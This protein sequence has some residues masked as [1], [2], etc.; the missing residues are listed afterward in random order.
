M[1][2]YTTIARLREASSSRV[3]GEAPNTCRVQRE[4]LRIA[5]NIID[6]LDADI[7]RADRVTSAAGARPAPDVGWGL[8]QG[9]TPPAPPPL[10]VRNRIEIKVPFISSIGMRGEVRLVYAG[11]PEGK[12]HLSVDAG[13]PVDG[14]KAGAPLTV[15]G[16]RVLV[17]GLMDCIY[18]VERGGRIAGSEE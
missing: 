7:R 10:P 15:D 2:F 1:S 17:D 18:A 3:R 13:H 14:G 4:D 5:L 6:R 8:W 16:M 11:G 12:A 9:L